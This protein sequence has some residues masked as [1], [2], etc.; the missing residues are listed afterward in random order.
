MISRCIEIFTCNDVYSK[1]S[2]VK[3]LH[4]DYINGVLEMR[5]E[6]VLDLPTAPSRPSNIREVHASKVKAKGN[7]GMIHSIVHAES[8]AIDLSL[9]IFLRF[10]FKENMPVE[11]YTDWLVVAY[12]EATHFERWNQ[13]L[14]DLG[15]NYGAFDASTGL[16][17]SATETNAS[18]LDRLAFVHLIAEARGLDTSEIAKEKL[19][20][21]NDVESIL[22][23]ERNVK[24]ETT[25]V[26]KA[27]K[28]F[29]FLC[30]RE[31]L[32]P[33][34]TFHHCVRRLYKGTFKPPFNHEARLAAG[35]T[36]EWYMPLSMRTGVDEEE[37]SRKDT[38]LDVSEEISLVFNLPSTLNEAHRN[39]STL[40]TVY[41][42][43]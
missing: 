6:D 4:D 21:S 13:R 36:P 31:S 16:W 5:W 40:M 14:Q 29:R 2:K 34:E 42:S 37:A 12:E 32:N 43:S 33:V 7:K 25:H 26:G 24:E 9:D 28:W 8:Y 23:L 1:C 19:R 30:D 3:A 15:S 38:P 20:K 35:M 11:F 41:T 27:V 22:V 39:F 18:L 10:G 17:D